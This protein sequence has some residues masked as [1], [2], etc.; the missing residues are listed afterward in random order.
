MRV[1]RSGERD[2][3]MIVGVKVSV[4]ELVKSPFKIKRPSILGFIVALVCVV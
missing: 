3:E 1:M 4:I 2:D